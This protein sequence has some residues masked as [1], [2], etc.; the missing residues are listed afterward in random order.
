[1]ARPLTAAAAVADAAQLKDAVRKAAPGDVILLRDGMWTDADL[2]IDAEGAPG[3]PITVRAETP[4]RVILTGRSRLHVGGRYIVVDGLFF[5]DGVVN[6]E[7]V[8]S[9]RASPT[10][11]ASECRITRCAIVDYKSKSKETDTKWLSVYGHKNRI[12]HCYLAGKT[13]LGTTLVVWLR[14]GDPTAEHLIDHN[15]F[16]PRPRLGLNGGETIRM[17][18][19]STSMLS[20][21]SRVEH[22]YFEKCNGEVEVISNKSCDNLYTGNLF[23]RCEGTLTLRHGNR[24]TVDGNFFFG[25][26]ARNTGGIRIIGEGHRVMNNYLE[27]LMGNHTRAAISMMNGIPNSP[28]NGYFQVKRATVESNIVVNCAESIVIGIG[29]NAK[30]TLAPESS[31]FSKNVVIGSQAPLVRVLSSG[32]GV[33]W[34]ENVFYGADIGLEH[35]TPSKDRPDVNAPKIDRSDMGPD[36]HRAASAEINGPGMAFA[37]R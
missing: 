15:H 3:R 32:A 16:G 21:K 30:A 19:S 12:D 20:A 27:G 8:I 37:V 35:L 22:N 26:G 6:S 11:L 14:E 9:L 28:A 25:F 5:K 17:G 10:R 7:A 2:V 33:R 36:W 13:N 29:D 31:V 4:G 23:E 1:M 18:D 34:E 24:C